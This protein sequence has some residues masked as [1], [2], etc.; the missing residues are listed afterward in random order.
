MLGKTWWSSWQL[1]HVAGMPHMFMDEKV[2][3][4]V[5]LGFS[6]QQPTY[7]AAYPNCAPS[8]ATTQTHE[9]VRDTFNS[10]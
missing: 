4:R 7:L 3:G 2:E 6:A 9:P 1:R 5:G 10:N 8:R